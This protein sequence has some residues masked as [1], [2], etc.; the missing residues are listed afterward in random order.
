MSKYEKTNAY[1]AENYF[2]VA[3]RIPKE[4]KEVLQKLADEES[5]SIN[6]LIVNAVEK[7]YGVNLSR[8]GD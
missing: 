7:F 8:K 6:K 5:T 2:K 1:N 4:K 3:L